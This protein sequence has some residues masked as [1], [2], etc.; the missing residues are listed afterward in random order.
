MLRG[1]QPTDWRILDY[2]V[3]AA[4]AYLGCCKRWMLQV[5]VEVGCSG[6][7]KLEHFSARPPSLS[8]ACMALNEVG[9]GGRAVAL[10][11]QIHRGLWHNIALPWC[12]QNLLWLCSAGFLAGDVS[13]P[14]IF[15]LQCHTIAAHTYLD[16][17]IPIWMLV[18]VQ[19][20]ICNPVPQ[21]HFFLISFWKEMLNSTLV[22]TAFVKHP[23]TNS[24]QQFQGISE[25]K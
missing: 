11:M 5:P 16:P 21:F 20:Q 23:I 6:R 7:K 22:H 13:E 24:L 3:S 25:E 9:A 2:S 19:H 14:E 8:C 18:I 10:G 12:T 4:E 17:G 15:F 1:L